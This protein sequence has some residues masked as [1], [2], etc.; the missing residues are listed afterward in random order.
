MAL[1]ASL[2][3]PLPLVPASEML[4]SFPCPSCHAPIPAGRGREA[5]S[6]AEWSGSCPACAEPYTVHE[7]RRLVSA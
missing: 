1:L 7:S 3:N 6:F 5:G 4:L 2:N